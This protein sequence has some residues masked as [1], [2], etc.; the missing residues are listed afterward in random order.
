MVSIKLSKLKFGICEF[1][2]NDFNIFKRQGFNCINANKFIVAHLKSD[3]D[4]E[5]YAIVEAFIVVGVFVKLQKYVD[6][7]KSI[8]GEQFKFFKLQHK[9]GERFDNFSLN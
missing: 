8:F 9:K 7:K 5:A 4:E 1:I 2:V 3:L 6:L